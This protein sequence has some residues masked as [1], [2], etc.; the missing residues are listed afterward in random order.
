M[1]NFGL[2]LAGNKEVMCACVCLILFGV[3]QWF[4]LHAAIPKGTL[5]I[6]CADHMPAGI[7][8]FFK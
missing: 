1:S 4:V 3:A 2:R 5:E 6:F 7:A 8:K